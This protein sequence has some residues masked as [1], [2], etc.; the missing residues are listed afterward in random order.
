MGTKLNQVIAIEKGV[1]S[2]VTAEITELH[3]SSQKPTLFNGFS[4]T[5]TKNADDGEDFPAERQ[6]VQFSVSDVLSKVTRAGTELMDIT[7]SKDWT[8][9]VARADVT[10]DGSVVIAQAPVSFLLFLEKQLTD[11][12]TFV[13]KLPVLDEAETWMKDPNSGLFRT[14][15]ISTH[16]TKK[17]PKVVVKYPATP[18]HPAQTELLQEDVIVGHWGTTKHSGAMPKPDRDAMALRVE[19]LLKAVKTAREAAN[20][21]EVVTVTGSGEQVFGYLFGKE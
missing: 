5:Y 6:R 20:M 18:E 16:K 19:K 9:C 1:K 21:E 4:K 12:R 7:A 14:D 13:D 3:K 15:P 8:N 11:M 10:V 17:V 2:R